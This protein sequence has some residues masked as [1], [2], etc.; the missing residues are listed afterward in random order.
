[1]KSNMPF[2]LM[3]RAQ[4]AINSVVFSPSKTNRLASLLAALSLSLSAVVLP[5]EAAQHAKAGVTSKTGT[6]SRVVDGDTVWVSTNARK[7]PLKV[8]ILGMDAPEICQAGGP[9]SQKALEGRLLGQT[10]TLA[11]PR[12]R[13]RDDYGRVLAKIE[14]R[15]EDVGGW[16]VSRGQA[17]SYGFRRSAGPYAEEQARAVAARRGLFADSRAENPRLF[18]KRHGSCYR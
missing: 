4:L 17:W 5:A 8:R 15:G 3:Q 1:M 9:A 14:L 13:S 7:K 2:A 6:V 12:S 16:M 18:R 10:V 11:V